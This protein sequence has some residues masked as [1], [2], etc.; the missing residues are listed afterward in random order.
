VR[1]AAFSAGSATDGSINILGERFG[2]GVEVWG[3]CIRYYRNIARL[4]DQNSQQSL[5]KEE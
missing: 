1:G 5:A 4:L 2:L 3:E